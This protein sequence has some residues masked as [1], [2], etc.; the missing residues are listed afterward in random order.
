[1]NSAAK[2]SP[3]RMPERSVPSSRRRSRRVRHAHRPT[4]TPAAIERIAACAIGGS[5]G[6][7]SFTKTCWKPQLAHR[8]IIAATATRSI[9]RGLV[10]GGTRIEARSGTHR[11]NEK[12]RRPPFPFGAVVW[13]DWN[14]GSPPSDHH[15]RHPRPAARFRLRRRPAARDGAVPR[16][17]ARA[18]A[19]P[20]RR[21]RSR[22]D[23]DREGALGGA[24]PAAH[25]AAVLCGAR[26]RLRRLRVELRRPDD[27]DPLGRG[28]RRGRPRA[29][30]IGPLLRSLPRAPAAAA[31]ARARPRRPA[32]APHRRARPHRRGI[33]GFPPR[34]AVRFPGHDPG[35][36]HGQGR[37][38]T[39]RH[40]H[41]EPHARDPRRAEAPL[42]LS[43]AR[44]PGR[45]ARARDPEVPRAAGAGEALEGDRR[46]R[47]G[48]PQGG[49]LQVAGRRRDPR[50]GLRPR[51]ARRR[52]PRPGAGF[53]YVGGAAEVSGRHSEDAGLEGQGR[54]RRSAGRREDVMTNERKA[55][56]EVV[57]TY[58]DGLYEGDTQKL[59]RVFHETSALTGDI[60]G[61]LTIVPRDKWLD[62]VKN[63]PSPKSQNLSRH[64]E[65]L[66]IDIAGP[67][68]AFVKVKC[69]I[70]PRFFTDYLSFL[71]IDGRW[72]VAQKIYA[73]DTREAARVAAE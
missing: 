63:R 38:A 2:I 54:A 4:S 24:R 25:P 26:R 46:L 42:P 7:A 12:G 28:R 67:T 72:Q 41:L 30:R 59:A 31:G 43:L 1:M 6:S 16:P 29:A 10:I 33:R 57:Q 19:V 64:D 53:G 17:E 40:H 65:I 11:A 15:R 36:R 45:A 9:N 62:A 73:A 13:L 34:G 22:Q 71:K 68:T 21:G 58:L 55:I 60:D 52:R 5:S 27:G 8:T 39:D 32:R 14:H 20:R 48:D 35:A 66:E 47:A 23:R 56:E 44:L 61:K 37:A 51:R 70:P 50:L 49:P 18:A 3:T 69:A